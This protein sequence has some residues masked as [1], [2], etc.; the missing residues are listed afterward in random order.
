MIRVNLTILFLMI[1]TVAFGQIAD[2]LK[3]AGQNTSAGYYGELMAYSSNGEDN[4]WVKDI[5]VSLRGERTIECK[6]TF[7]D[8]KNAEYWTFNVGIL[9]SENGILAGDLSN[10]TLDDA[11]GMAYIDEKAK[12]TYTFNEEE[13]VE[14]LSIKNFFIHNGYEIDVIISWKVPTKQVIGKTY[15][16][17]IRESCSRTRD[18]GYMT[19]TYCSLAFEKNSV[20]ITE[21]STRNFSGKNIN[22]ERR[23]G[24]SVQGNNITI[25]TFDAYGTLVLDGENLIG[26]Q[27]IGDFQLKEFVF[28]E[29]SR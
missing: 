26:Q 20:T 1:S 2:L 6:L 24:Y 5:Y 3:A 23:Y 9:R 10:I 28:K 11:T 17:R 19:Y 29:V 4:V 27:R 13:G 25:N 8:G 15:E 22:Y 21:Y 14:T 16:A 18:G 12:G 7:E